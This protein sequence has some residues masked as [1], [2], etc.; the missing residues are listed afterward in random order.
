MVFYFSQRCLEWSAGT[1]WAERLSA[2]RLFRYITVRSAGAA[3]TALMLSLFLG[4]RV[5]SWLKQIK[6][7]Q[8]Y[9]DKAEV[10]GDLKAGS[11]GVVP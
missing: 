11:G 6:F 10:G 1:V 4:P 2:L 8:E 5:I 3:L 7:G 9:L